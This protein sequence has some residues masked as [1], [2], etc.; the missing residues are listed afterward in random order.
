MGKVGDGCFVV[1]VFSMRLFRGL[2][3]PHSLRVPTH[4][5]LLQVQAAFA[6]LPLHPASGVDEAVPAPVVWAH[7]VA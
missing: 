7:R 1:Y 5:P 3:H 2:T 6:R 4:L